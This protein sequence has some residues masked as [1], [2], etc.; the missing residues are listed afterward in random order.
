MRINTDQSIKLGQRLYAR[1][2]SWE[3]VRQASKMR[4]GAYIVPAEPDQRDARARIA[5]E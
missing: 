3:A 1:Y 4:D 5:A 2:G